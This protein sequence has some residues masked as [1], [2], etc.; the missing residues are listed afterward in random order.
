M[1]SI[2]RALVEYKQRG[3]RLTVGAIFSFVY[4]SFRYD[5]KYIWRPK[6]LSKKHLTISLTRSMTK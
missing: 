6:I 3:N 1:R 4:L 5:W 2:Y